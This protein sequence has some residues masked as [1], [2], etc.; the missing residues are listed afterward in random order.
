[1]RGIEEKETALMLA[2][3]DYLLL[4]LSPLML[5]LTPQQKI[6]LVQ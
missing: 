2:S 1:M 4:L 5:R 3:L 6:Q